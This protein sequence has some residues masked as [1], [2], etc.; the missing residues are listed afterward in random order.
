MEEKIEALIEKYRNRL[1]DGTSCINT[2]SGG[3]RYHYHDGETDT[4]VDIIC[5]LDRVLG[6]TEAE[7]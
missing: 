5:D 7:G 3:G 1:G 4:L 2:T 6:Q